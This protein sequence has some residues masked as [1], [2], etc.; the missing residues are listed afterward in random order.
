MD[1]VRYPIGKFEPVHD[2]SDDQRKAWIKD[3]AEAPSNLRLAIEGLSSEQ[4]D[5]Q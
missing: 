3:L 4:L 2:V 1:E 5:T